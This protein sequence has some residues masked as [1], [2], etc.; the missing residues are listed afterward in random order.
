MKLFV[1]PRVPILILLLVFLP[2]CLAAISVFDVIRLSQGRYSDEEIIRL[3]QT[4]DSRFVLSAEDTVRLRGAGVTESVIREMLSR[5]A[6]RR[7]SEP[8]ASDGAANPSRPSTAIGGSGE[9]VRH[10]RRPEPLFAG[11]PYQ[12]GSRDHQAHAAVTLAEIEVL[13]VR[14][15]AGFSSPLAR[16][17]AVART[18]NSLAASAAGRFAVRAVGRDSKVIFESSDGAA[19]DIVT[20]TPADVAAYRVAGR[21]QVSSGTLSSF[22]AALLNDYWAVGVAGK[23]PRSLV[24]SREGQALTRLSRAVRLPVGTHDPAA[25]RAGFDSLGRTD[26]ELLRKLP[27]AVPED[28]QSPLRRSP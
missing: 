20:V 13:I 19:T 2:A 4:T 27:T 8:A 18:L 6:P 24:D 17:R 16:A 21:Q 12:E 25:V 28:L 26:R 7:D 9:D 5:P 15:Q 10:V 11:S 3:I 14:D 22:W 1:S 23:P